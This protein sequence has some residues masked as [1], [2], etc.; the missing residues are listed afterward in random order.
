MSAHTCNDDRDV[1]ISITASAT[2]MNTEPTTL[3]T[4]NTNDTTNQPSCD[5]PTVVATTLEGD[6][7]KT[8][9]LKHTTPATNKS[10]N[11]EQ[12]GPPANSRC[13]EVDNNS[14][15]TTLATDESTNELQKL[16]HGIHN[17]I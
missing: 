16:E 15:Q 4:T 6:G 10:A 2:T 8:K 11:D 17:C 13:G 14:L 7:N 9:Q 5:K 3:T 1:P 12:T